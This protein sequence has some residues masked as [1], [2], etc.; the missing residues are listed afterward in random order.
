MLFRYC[1][2]LV[3]SK[4]LLEDF[5]NLYQAIL[6]YGGK[7]GEW[8]PSG[9]SLHGIDIVDRGLIMLFF[10]LFFAIFDLFSV[11]LLLFLKY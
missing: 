7:E 11:A 10:G 1:S 9:F 2:L 5:S 8:P 6:I 3:K 4:R